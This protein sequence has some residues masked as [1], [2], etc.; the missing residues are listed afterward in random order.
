M[1]AVKRIAAFAPTGNGQSYVQMLEIVKKLGFGGLELYQYDDLKTPDPDV[2]KRIAERAAELD[3]T[4]PCLSIGA[5]LS[6]S[7]QAAQME[8]VKQ[9]IQ[10][11]EAAG[12]PYIHFTTAPYMQHLRDFVPLGKLIR[13]VA[14]AVKAL[15]DFAGE[16]HVGCVVEGQGYYINGTEPLEQLLEAVDHPNLGIVADLGNLLCVD[17]QPERFVGWFAPVVHHVHIKDM[18]VQ[19]KPT[20]E[21]GVRWTATKHGA[22]LHRTELGEGIIDIE[23]C[24]RIL[25][26]A[27]YQGN[28]SIENNVIGREEK[29]AQDLR[30]LTGL[31]QEVFN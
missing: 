13:R 3:M 20:D 14:P 2:A 22:Y 15:C 28:F 23:R 19:A 24:L 12:A 11:A 9:Y 6:G 21:P 1:E 7:D 16:H 8:R 29:A 17:E 27:G 18:V 31:V 26:A 25:A 4:I 30:Y 5:D 10:V